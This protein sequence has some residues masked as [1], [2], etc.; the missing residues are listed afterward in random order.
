MAVKKPEP[1]FDR[2]T[3]WK[4][5]ESK[6]ICVGTSPKR[7]GAIVLHDGLSGLERELF[8]SGAK[9]V[10]LDGET[11]IKVED[12]AELSSD[13]KSVLRRYTYRLK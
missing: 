13:G 6:P 8:T 3:V 2:L 10:K 9:T 1:K 11:Y 4:Y 5:E 7:K 12:N